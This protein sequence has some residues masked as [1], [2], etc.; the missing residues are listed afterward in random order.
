M[1]APAVQY[2]AGV[3]IVVVNYRTASDLADF[4]HSLHAHRPTVDFSLVIVNVDPTPADVRV[5]EWATRMFDNGTHLRTTEN[6]GYGRAC[7]LAAREHGTRQTLALFNADVRLT[8]VVI[9]ECCAALWAFPD[10]AV[11]GPR[12]IDD[13]GKITAAG[14][15]GTLDAPRHRGWQNVDDGRYNDVRPDAVTA[16]GAAYFIKRPVWDELTEC[17]VYRRAAPEAQGAFL[18]TPHYYEETF[19]SYH[20]IAH[21]YS[22]VYYGPAYVIHRWHRASVVGGWAEQQMPISQRMFREACDLHG[23]PHD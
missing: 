18:S 12:Q 4:V 1:T 21:G 10:W 5:G 13:N 15:F 16:S 3:D 19:C 11:V 20:A 8:P 6:I 14:I 23:I 2:P 22:V 17:P 9:D 7:N